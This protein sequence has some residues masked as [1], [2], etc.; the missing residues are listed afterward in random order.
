MR[1]ATTPNTIPTGTA[2]RRTFFGG[3]GRPARA[4]TTGILVTVRAGREAARNVA[5]TA[6]TI[7]MTITSHGSWNM[8]I[9]WCALA[10]TCGR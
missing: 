1:N 7:A 4:V 9:T 3:A 6:R 2:Q 10:S 8:P 5:T